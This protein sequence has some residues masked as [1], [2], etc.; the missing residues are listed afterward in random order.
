M[1]L[2]LY[3]TKMEVVA[4]PP[5]DPPVLEQDG[6]EEPIP[7]PHVL[8]VGQDTHVVAELDAL[9]ANAERVIDYAQYGVFADWPWLLDKLKKKWPPKVKVMTVI[10]EEAFQYHI[11]KLQGKLRNIVALSFVL[12]DSKSATLWL[13]LLF[14]IL[15]ELPFEEDFVKDIASPDSIRLLVSR[16]VNFCPEG[17]RHFNLEPED[18]VL[19]LFK[20]SPGQSAGWAEGQPDAGWRA[21]HDTFSKVSGAEELGPKNAWDRRFYFYSSRILS[22]VRAALRKVK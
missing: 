11:G 8:L 7:G 13:N 14:E 4:A 5:T 17:N 22:L 15:T 10:G 19:D 16:V 9:S 6:G 2:N 1:A 12:D 21:V 3:I 20:V 18:S